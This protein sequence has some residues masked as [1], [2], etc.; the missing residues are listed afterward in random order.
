[1]ACEFNQEEPFGACEMKNEK[2]I[3]LWK[4]QS[5]HDDHNGA[6][7]RLQL[8]RHGIEFAELSV[9]PST[10]FPMRSSIQQSQRNYENGW[11][12][13]SEADKKLLTANCINCG[14][15]IREAKRLCFSCED[16]L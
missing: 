12:A 13:Q 3:E 4:Q 15:L 9:A 10:F 1:L 5:K 11:K 6:M 7:A 8:E 16:R 2:L 14:R